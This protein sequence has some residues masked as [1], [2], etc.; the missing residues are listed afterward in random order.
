MKKKNMMH[1]LLGTGLGLTAGSIAV[2]ALP[3][4]DVSPHIQ[5]GMVKFASFY[6]AFGSLAGAKVTLDLTKKVVKSTK[7]LNGRKMLL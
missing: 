3:A 6:P 5:A 1:G 2:G 7:K 4:N